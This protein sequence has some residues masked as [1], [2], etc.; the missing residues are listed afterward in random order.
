MTAKL[1][2]SMIAAERG[3]GWKEIVGPSRRGGLVAVRREAMWACR[4][5]RRLDG[6]PRYS[7]P[8]LGRLFNRDH[9]TILWACKSYEALSREN[10]L[11]TAQRNRNP[12]RSCELRSAGTG[13]VMGGD[14]S[15]LE[16]STAA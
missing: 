4:Q 6:K 9:T 5:V 14:G 16:R 7:L 10:A 8:F 12:R 2:A 15:V 13:V 1:L 3:Y 11:G